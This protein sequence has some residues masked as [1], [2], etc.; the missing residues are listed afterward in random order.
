M[1]PDDDMDL[2]WEQDQQQFEQDEIEAYRE[3][4]EDNWPDVEEDYFE[5]DAD[6]TEYQDTFIQEGDDYWEDFT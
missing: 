5:D 2:M 3:W 4:Y 1:Y 6:F